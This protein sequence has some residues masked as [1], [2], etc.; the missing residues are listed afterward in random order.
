MLQKR[1]ES[2]IS[3]A[4]SIDKSKI[5]DAAYSNETQVSP[6]KLMNYL[7]SVILGLLIPFIIIYIKNL[8][9]TKVHDERDIVRLKIPYLGDVPLAL[10][11]KNLYLNHG[12]NSNIAEAFRYVR[13]SINFMLDNKEK[14]KTVF[15][16]ST[17]KGEGKTF[18]AINL[19]LSLANSGKKTLLLAMDL[20]NP[21]IFKYLDIKNKIGVS[22][23]IKNHE[24]TF[25]EIKGNYPKFSNLDIIDSGDIPPNP[26]ELLMSNR[27]QEL[28]DIAT[29]SY[30]YVIVDTAPV[31]MVT[32]TIQ[33][34]K[35]A[36][37]TI[38]VIR[39]NSLDRRMLNIPEKLHKENKLK[40]MSILINGTDHSKG[41]YGY[42]YEYGYGKKL[43]KRWYKK[44]FGFLNYK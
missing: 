41:A 11:K 43:E 44:V 39:S 23:F 27:V 8:L 9:D 36:D 35:F 16:T 17:Q 13:T 20:R 32:D 38:Y 28:F 2:I 30:K 26:V 6:N 10:S 25:N 40:N 12:D 5:I 37:L 22:N 7:G 3:N 18:T 29:E 33:I 14:G 15:I 42:G 4:V 21:K 24:L 34:S 19:A 1:E 31:G